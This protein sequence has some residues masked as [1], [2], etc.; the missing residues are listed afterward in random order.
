VRPRIHAI[1]ELD[2]DATERL[3]LEAERLSLC[4]EW[5]KE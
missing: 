1:C 3:L 2:K 5:D 4:F